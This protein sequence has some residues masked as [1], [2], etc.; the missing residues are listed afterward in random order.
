MFMDL[1]V[2]NRSY[3]GYDE[4][5]KITKEEMLDMINHARLCASSVNKQ[6]LKYYVAYDEEMVKKIQPLTGWAKALD[7]KLP[8][9]GKCPTGFIVICQDTNIMKNTDAFLRDVGIVA[10]TMLLR[11]VEMGLGGCMIGN[12]KVEDIQKTLHLK[13]G[14]YPHL[15]LAIGKPDEEVIITDVQDQKTNYYRDEEDR[16]YVPKRSLED[17]LI[18]E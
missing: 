16:H 13:E 11:A 10:Q 17:L 18:N 2:Q 1:V 7:M 8:H 12:F 9:D 4:S 3:R 15:I 6:P 14:I 5:R